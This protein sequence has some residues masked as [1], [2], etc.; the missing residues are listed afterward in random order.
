MAKAKHSA[1]LEEMAN[2]IKPCS[3]SRQR[4]NLLIYKKI[5]RKKFPDPKLARDN[6]NGQVVVLTCIKRNANQNSDIILYQMTKTKSLTI[7]NVCEAVR[8]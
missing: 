6:M 8:K 3:S 7:H 5:C 4:P 1:N 2:W